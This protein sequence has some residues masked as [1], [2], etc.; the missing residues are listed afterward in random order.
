MNETK[1]Q[2]KHVPSPTRSTKNSKT[3]TK[4]TKTKKSELQKK[5]QKI[6][7][8]AREQPIGD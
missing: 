4:K 8:A 5:Q 6:A 1:N 3:K 7:P 2:K